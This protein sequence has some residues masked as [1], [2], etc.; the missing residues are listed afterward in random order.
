MFAPVVN[1]IVPP[2]KTNLDKTILAPPSPRKPRQLRCDV[3]P[4]PVK[5]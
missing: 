2:E 3:P 4:I 5:V 1:H